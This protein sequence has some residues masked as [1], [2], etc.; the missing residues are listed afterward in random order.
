MNRKNLKGWFQ[1]ALRDVDEEICM[2]NAMRGEEKLW[3]GKD[4]NFF[5]DWAEIFVQLVECDERRGETDL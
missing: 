4:E 5:N 2:L 3:G 1:S